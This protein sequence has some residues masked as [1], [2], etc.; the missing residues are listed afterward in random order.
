MDERCLVVRDLSV[1]FGHEGA[2]FRA[3][4]GVSF[5]LSRGRTLAIVGESGSGKSVT[6]NAVM[7]LLPRA[8][9]IAS[10]SILFVDPMDAARRAVDIATL[11]RDGEEIRALRGA[12]IA[13][14]F[15]EPMIS[16]SPLHTIGDQIGEALMLHAR[17]N[18]AAADARTV[19]LLTRVG[20]RDPKGALATYPFE[21]SGGMRDD[22]HGARLQPR[23]SGGG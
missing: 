6:A 15:Q 13:M 19:E 20:F 21:L 11:A 12:R 1:E 8:G 23:H 3:I 18:R 10:G 7:G 5:D 17:V 2:A 14:I 4:D 9:R 22:R 16:L